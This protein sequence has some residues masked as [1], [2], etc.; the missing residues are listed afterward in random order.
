MA[1]RFVGIDTAP[2][3]RW[4]NRIAL[5][6]TKLEKLDD[7]IGELMSQRV[8]AEEKLA[9]LYGQRNAGGCVKP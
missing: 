1:P 8:D 2:H 3:D 7:R 5:L 4:S 9:A 6:E